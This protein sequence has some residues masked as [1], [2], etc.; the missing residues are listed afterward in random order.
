MQEPPNVIVMP[1]D[2]KMGVNQLGDALGSPQTGGPAVCISTIAEHGFQ[3]L[4]LLGRQARRRPQM[5][6]GGQA[7]WF[8]CHLQP[9][10]NGTLGDTEYSGNVLHVVALMDSLDGPVSPPFQFRGGSI[11]SAHMHLDAPNGQ[12][13]HYPRS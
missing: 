12:K 3:L 2:A 5:G 1:G 4:F 13:S 11:R 9:A 7:V 10:V 8:F 6:P